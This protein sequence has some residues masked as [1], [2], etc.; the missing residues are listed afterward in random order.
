MNSPDAT[1]GVLF[2]GFMLSSALYGCSI[3]QSYLFYTRY[4]SENAYLKALVS[5]LFAVDTAFTGLLSRTM[6]QY[7]I[8]DFIVP[9]DHLDVLRTF[10][11]SLTLTNT[12]MLLVQLY[13]FIVTILPIRLN[14]VISFYAYRTWSINEHR[15]ALP[16]LLS[17]M[18]VV[19]FALAIETAI[20]MSKQTLLI[21]IV[22]SRIELLAGLSAGLATLCNIIIVGTQYFYL[23]PSR[24][25]A[26]KVQ[27]GW[28]DNGILHLFTRGVLFT[29]L[30]LVLLLTFIVLPRQYVWVCFHFII[31]KVYA[32]SVLIMLNSRVS[33][34]GRG[35][36]EEDSLKTRSRP[37]SGP[38][39]RSGSGQGGFRGL[40]V[41]SMPSDVDSKAGK[42]VT[43]DLGTT[44]SNSEIDVVSPQDPTVKPVLDEEMFDSTTELRKRWSQNM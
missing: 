35:L 38:R 16:A 12:E 28:F 13:V 25:P 43:M 20:Q 3:F 24:Q 42:N 33:Y 39:R 11:T 26:M 4:P 23:H 44:P 8:N 6:Y 34:Y 9:F 1:F 5:I 40:T 21:Y 17:L 41:P 32:N 18:A 10:V 22:T 2:I 27:H 36:S 14:L 30:Q 7:L 31:G 37:S 29:A 15:P 19:S